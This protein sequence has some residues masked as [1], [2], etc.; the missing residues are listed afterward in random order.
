[1]SADAKREVWSSVTGAEQSAEKLAEAVERYITD[2]PESAVLEDGTLLFDLRLARYSLSL[3]HGRCLL[4]FWSEE[5]NLVRT[6]V[7]AQLRAGC[8]RLI[9]RRMGVSKP[10]ALEIVGQRDRRTPT[11]RESERRQ[12]QRLLERVLR[13]Q[14]PDWT[15]DGFRS[16]ADLEHSFGPAYVRG[17]LLQGSRGMQAEAVIG[18]GAAESR[19]IVDG[20]LTVGLL[21]MDHCRT[22]NVGKSARQRHYGALRVIVPVGM[23]QTTA[24]RM[25]WLHPGLAAWRLFTLDEKTEELTAVEIQEDGNQSLRLTHAFDAQAA[26]ERAQPGIE[27]LLALLPAH[28]AACVEVRAR[29]ATEVALLL[30]GLEFARIR[31]QAAYGSFARTFEVTFGAGG[32]ETP[33]NEETEP[34]CRSLLARLFA[35]RHP[36]GTIKDAL[37]RL[38]TERWLESRIRTGMVEF[39]PSLRQEFL[40]TQVPAMA[41]GD[42]GMMDLL[43][44]DRSGRMVILEVKAD[45]DLH[46]PLQA[47]DYWMRVRAL[48][49]DRGLDRAT[50]RVLDAFQRNGYFPGVEISDSPP[51]ILL[52]APALRI[53]PANEIVLRYLSPQVDWELLAVGEDWRSSLKTVF[54]K[55][56][57]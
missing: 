30:E 27:T 55:R 54:H 38:Q 1:M 43:T 39:L 29:E 44:V 32:N 17:Q 22:H 46:L 40:Y 28:S 4:Q 16:A 13:R 52:V 34:L 31:Q 8:L 12:Y 3:A 24:A 41:S 2:H 19:A 21:W 6:V 23:E 47:L 56:R 11:A 20:V 45:E 5:R 51:K 53:H 36:N 48:H 33:L 10:G 14:F 50:G 9:T 35:A 49:G 57:E 18:V 26:I 42:R 7:D 15:P 37:F 25:R